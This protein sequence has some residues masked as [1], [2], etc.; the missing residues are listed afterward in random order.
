LTYNKDVGRIADLQG[1][2]LDTSS[3][4]GEV[5]F[6]GIDLDNAHPEISAVEGWSSVLFI[7]LSEK[8]TGIQINSFELIAGGNRITPTS[9]SLQGNVALLHVT[10]LN[11]G[12]TASVKFSS[13][14][15]DT[16]LDLNKQKPVVETVYFTVP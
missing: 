12:T 14:A 11:A 10:G 16:V 1:E 9:V 8:V 15:A 2:R 5:K 7:T 3:G 4:R 13:Q 6:T